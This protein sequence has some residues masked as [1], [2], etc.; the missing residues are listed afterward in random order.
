MPEATKHQC[1]YIEIRSAE[2]RIV[3]PDESY[4]EDVENV[5]EDPADHAVIMQ[6]EGMPGTTTDYLCCRHRTRV[7][8]ELMRSEAL[9]VQVVADSIIAP[10][11]EYQV[12]PAPYPAMGWCYV[13]KLVSAHGAGHTMPPVMLESSGYDAALREAEAKVERLRQIA[14]GG[15]A[16]L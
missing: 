16:P 13:V 3:G 1:S 2:I 9:G 11:V 14:R 8:D 10:T 15:D 4:A 6:V 12:R 5:C 7:I